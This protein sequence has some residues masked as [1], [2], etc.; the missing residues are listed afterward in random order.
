MRKLLFL[1]LSLSF[2]TQ[3]QSLQPFSYTA[4]NTNFEGFVAFPEKTDASTKTI[5]IVHEWWG[6]NQ[7]PKDRAVALAKAGFIAVCLDM[8]GK[9]VVVD[10]P[11]AAG[12]LA[13]KIY[14]DPNRMYRIFSAGM[15]AARELKGVQADK[16]AAI[17]YCFGGNVVL[18]AAKLGAPLDAVVSFHGGLQGPDAD[19]DKLKAAVLVCHGAADQFVS[20]AEITAFDQGL[21]AIKADY[22]F[23]SYPDATHA[24]SNPYSTAVGKQF[25]IPIAYNEA[26]DKKSY[27]DF[28]QFVAAKVK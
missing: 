23:I 20:E 8:Y 28:L 9:G 3:A 10:N 2:S 21:K 18:N 15:A 5:L 11:Q 1:F 4:E 7:Y 22:Q 13:G 19:A 12:E 25:N 24:F 26:A 16:M 6:L 17:G 14:A 27:A